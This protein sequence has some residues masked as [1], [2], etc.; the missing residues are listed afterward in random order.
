MVKAG[1][2]SFCW[3]CC[4]CISFFM[5]TMSVHSAILHIHHEYGIGY[6]IVAFN[7]VFIWV[8]GIRLV[9][10]WII[11]MQLIFH[12]DMSALAMSWQCL[13]FIRELILTMATGGSNFTLRQNLVLENTLNLI[14]KICKTIFRKGKWTNQ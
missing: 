5:W 8:K 10:Q 6:V 1:A 13:N 3:C 9:L 7:M 12:W 11:G 2:S 4:C 14:C